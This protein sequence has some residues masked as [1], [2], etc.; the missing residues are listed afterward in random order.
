M[1]GQIE[2]N[3]YDDDDND[4]DDENDNNDDNDDDDDVGGNPLRKLMRGRIEGNRAEKP[5][6]AGIPNCP[7]LPTFPCSGPPSSS[8]SPYSSSSLSSSHSLPFL[9]RSFAQCSTHHH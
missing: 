7:F 1:R 5:G 6:E 3:E 4:D 2:G 8:S 9:K